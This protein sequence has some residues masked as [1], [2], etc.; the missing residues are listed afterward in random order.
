MPPAADEEGETRP[1]LDE[2]A[3]LAASIQGAVPVRR[4]AKEVPEYRRSTIPRRE[5]VGF[6]LQYFAVGIVY[7]GLPSTIYG[8]FLGYL[9]VEGY[10]YA[11]AAT[12]VSLPWS[13]KFVFGAIN[14]CF[15]IF[16]YRRKP[17]MVL[18]WAA[19][20]A[21]LV[22]LAFMPL[23]EP[24]WC[25][26]AEGTGY[27]RTNVVNGVTEAARPCNPQAAEAGGRY[28]FLMM[29]ASL[30]YCVA[31]VA[32]DGLTVSLARLEPEDRRGQTQTSVYLV[33]TL[34]NVVA[35]AIVGLCMNSWQYNGSFTW[36]MSYSGIMGLFAVPA[37]AMVP[38]S[39]LL[40]TESR[41]VFVDEH[42]VKEDGR[43]Q[44]PPGVTYEARRTVAQYGRQVWELLRGRAMLCV[45]LFQFLTP[46]IGGVSTTAGGE[47]KQYWA[48]VKT[49]QNA[50][51]SMIGLALFAAG[52]YLVKTHLLNASWR[53]MLA[54]TT[55]F[56]NIVDM[57]FTFCTI[58]DVVRNQYFYLGETVLVEIPAAANFVV[59]TFVIVEMAEGGDEGIVYGLLTTTANL[60]GPFAQAISNQMF[61][62]WHP[63]LSDS[64]NY[65]EDAPSFRNAVAASF[66]VSYA[67]SFLSLCTL[68]LLPGQKAEAQDRKKRWEKKD[69][70]AY[71][72][73]ILISGGLVYSVTVNFLAMFPATMCLKI[74]G[75]DGCDDG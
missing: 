59:S 44:A 68:P 47:V 73:V 15:P 7:G 9:N 35:T 6:Y 60:G 8:F 5:L 55:I 20:A 67:F 19:C 38:V 22:R 48:N 12:I 21:A 46:I 62:L 69:A 74:A 17:Y 75:G 54:I 39:W 14:D 34:G 13:F 18:G 64:A 40:V 37:L 45:V 71:V 24:Y 25:I 63:S 51:F 32:A 52:L 53:W 30:G 36:G 57:P 72:S 4:D 16:G 58:F 27:V 26:D 49:F 61:G 56:L 66:A 29:L 70:Y 33:R 3:D 31:D 43:P 2:E 23:P 1:L 42:P 10:V 65:I 50:C 41:V 11:T 28:A